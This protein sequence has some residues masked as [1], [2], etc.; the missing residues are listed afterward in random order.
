MATFGSSGTGSTTSTDTMNI[1]RD[2]GNDTN[3]TLA[4]NTVLHT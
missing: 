2:A 1:M 3:V 4:P